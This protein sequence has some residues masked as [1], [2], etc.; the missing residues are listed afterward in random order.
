MSSAR[1]VSSF[2]RECRT[3]QNTLMTAAS[4]AK[5]TNAR[6]IAYAPTLAPDERLSMRKPALPAM[7]R[8]SR[9]TSAWV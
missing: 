2:C 7:K 1:P 5:V 6:L 9:R 4:T 8:V 3:T